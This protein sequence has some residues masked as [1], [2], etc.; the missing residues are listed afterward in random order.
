[1]LPVML[2][3]RKL[4]GEDPNTV[5]MVRFA[6]AAVQTLC[7]LVVLWTY[8]KASAIQNST[9]I[10]VPPPAQVSVAVLPACLPTFV[11]IPITCWLLAC[12]LVALACC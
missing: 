4:D 11:A 10:Y 5:Y 7:V 1:M 8:L 3:A 12:L 2:V 6:Y 9:T